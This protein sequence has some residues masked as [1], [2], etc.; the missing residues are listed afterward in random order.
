[1]TQ[2][3]DKERAAR[4]MVCLPLDGLH[5]L[6][7]VRSMVE[8]LSPYVGLFKVGKESFTRFGPEV[9]RQVH[10]GGEIL[11]EPDRVDDCVA[12]LSRRQRCEQPEHRRSDHLDRRGASRV[13]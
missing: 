8:E 1:M 11:T 4:D 6:H 2:L 10:E 3:S 5:T 13:V 7:A 12:D 9:V